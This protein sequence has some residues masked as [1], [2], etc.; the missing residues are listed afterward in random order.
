MSGDLAIRAACSQDGNLT[1]GSLDLRTPAWWLFDLLPLWNYGPVRGADVIV[2]LANF[3]QSRRRRGDI[4]SYSLRMI[5]V[6]AVD[7]DGVANADPWDGLQANIATLRAGLDPY[8]GTYTGGRTATLLMPN[9]ATRTALVHTN[10][11]VGETPDAAGPDQV[12]VPAVLDLVLPE[13]PFA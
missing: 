8:Q 9:G 5:I 4:A 12:V 1:V 2:P 3:G 11:E 7:E 10:L 6:G 13:G